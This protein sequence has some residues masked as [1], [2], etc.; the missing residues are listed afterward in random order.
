MVEIEIIE[1]DGTLLPSAINEPTHRSELCEG[2]WHSVP[3]AFDGTPTL[4][5]I[6]VVFEGETVVLGHTG[7]TPLGSI[8]ISVENIRDNFKKHADGSYK[9]GFAYNGAFQPPYTTLVELTDAF[10]DNSNDS[11][12]GT[13]NLLEDG[14][15]SYTVFDASYDDETFASLDLG[16][17][18]INGLT[19]NNFPYEEEVVVIYDDHPAPIKLDGPTEVNSSIVTGSFSDA[20]KFTGDDYIYMEKTPPAGDQTI[21]G[22]IK[23]NQ[24]SMR[25]W[26][27]SAE[28]PPIVG[29]AQD[30]ILT[31]DNNGRVIYYIWDGISQPLQS[32]VIINDDEWHHVAVVYT[33]G[34]GLTIYIDGDEDTS[35]ATGVPFNEY[36]TS[37]F[38][39]A[40]TPNAYFVGTLDAIQ[41]FEK[42]LSLSEIQSIYN[43]EYLLHNNTLTNMPSGMMMDGMG[44]YVVDEDQLYTLSGDYT[45]AGS[46]TKVVAFGN[47]DLE[48]ATIGQVLVYDGV[49]W[50]PLV[51]GTNGIADLAISTDH[52]ADR[53]IL[54]VKIDE[55][56]IEF[57][58][59]ADG[60]IGTISIQDEAVLS[61]NFDVEYKYT[62]GEYVPGSPSASID[63]SEM[64]GKSTGNY[65]AID[66]DDG[67]KYLYVTKT[68]A[69]INEWYRAEISG[70]A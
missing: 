46:W 20:Y 63:L 43:R 6:P 50:V 48:S 60:E 44:V 26:G 10:L 9:I 58:H 61:G 35:L 11:W 1:I 68:T 27:F 57:T 18:I 2:G 67:L 38:T 42:N 65:Y 5:P 34:V 70:W 8:E 47:T 45:V 33:L 25:V 23:T 22:W 16:P 4:T 7:Q 15:Y 3:Y 14:V 13:I 40:A 37:Y 54:G 49:D 41:I 36:L 29:G 21:C 55:A 30:R 53:S 56:A 17:F 12:S 52:I 19:S 39:L 62:L 64:Y 51:V 28:H 31:I 59:I 66:D 69:S 24:H 32:T